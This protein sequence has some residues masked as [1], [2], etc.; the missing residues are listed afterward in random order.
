MNPPCQFALLALF[1]SCAAA[2][3]GR[4]RSVA[5]VTID[6]DYFTGSDNNYSNG[7]ALS[8]LLGPT[9]EAPTDAFSRRWA[10][11]FDFLPLL[12]T[13]GDS[14]YVGASIGQEIHTPDDLSSPT[15][16]LDDQPY[17]GILFVDFAFAGRGENQCSSWSL[18]LGTV[19]PESCAE[20]VQRE[21]HE[22]N[23]D[24][25]PAGWD[26]Q[27]PSEPIVNLDYNVVYEVDLVGEQEFAARLMPIGGVSAGSYFTGVSAATYLEF[28]WNLAGTVGD[29]N[30]RQ[31]VDPLGLISAAGHSGFSLSG[32]VGAGGFAVGHYLPLDGTVFRNSRSVESE[33]L[34]G[35]GS[36]GGT[37]RSGSFVLTYLVS[38]FTE[39]F[40]TEREKSD[41]G[42]L[43]LS[44]TF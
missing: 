41:F 16:P 20:E 30:L 17:A 43:T 32:F 18:R 44:W 22:W 3:D 7:V 39:R 2:G 19:G 13:R 31:G 27:L 1:S 26:T 28:G 11:R 35:F 29:L 9:R 38:F 37:M 4:G 25:A 33:P 34:V 10:E 21:F 8:Y 23:S 12:D 15:P 42:R 6:N 36:A 24:E 5:G 14:V 40:E